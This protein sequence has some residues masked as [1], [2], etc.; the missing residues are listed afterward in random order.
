MMRNL[1][2]EEA[3]QAVAALLAVGLGAE[4]HLVGAHLNVSKSLMNSSLIEKLRRLAKVC[5]K[6]DIPT[7]H[8]DIGRNRDFVGLE[9]KE[10]RVLRAEVDPSSGLN[11]SRL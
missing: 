2:L 8:A 10:L 11:R 7:I 3:A 9:R 6:H 1:A 5:H 4:D